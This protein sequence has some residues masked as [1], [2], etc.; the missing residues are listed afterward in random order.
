[1]RPGDREQAG[2]AGGVDLLR[3]KQNKG[4]VTDGSGECLLS[5]L[6]RIVEVEVGDDAVSSPK[7]IPSPWHVH[8]LS[9]VD[10]NRDSVTIEADAKGRGGVRQQVGHPNGRDRRCSRHSGVQRDLLRD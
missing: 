4:S 2:L 6:R 10:S 1:M 3:T 9:A 7:K 8:D 5:L